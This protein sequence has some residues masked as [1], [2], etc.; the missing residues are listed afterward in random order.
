MLRKLERG[1]DESGGGREGHEVREGEDESG[2]G[3]EGRKVR[4]G[5]R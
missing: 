3:C 5:W 1:E 2:G 4:E